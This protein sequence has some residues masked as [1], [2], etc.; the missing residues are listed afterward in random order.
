M[1]ASANGIMCHV[2]RFR[3]KG[4]EQNGI[5]SK[6]NS[7]FAAIIPREQNGNVFEY[8]GTKPTITNR[9]TI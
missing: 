5:E 1:S 8:T 6:Y 7:R 9:R 2:L 4:R 3:P